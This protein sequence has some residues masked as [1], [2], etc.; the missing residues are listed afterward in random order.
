E[1]LRPQER[2]RYPVAF[3][4]LDRVP[5]GVLVPE[6]RTTRHRELGPTAWFSVR[7]G[8]KEAQRAA[9]R[10]T[11]LPG[12]AAIMRDRV[13]F[14]WTLMDAF[15]EEAERMVGPAADLYHRKTIRQTSRHALEL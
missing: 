1:G 13:A 14:A 5:E 11:D 12:Y 6:T 8:G 7:A 9:W 4:P 10:Y 15:Y 3:F 2:D